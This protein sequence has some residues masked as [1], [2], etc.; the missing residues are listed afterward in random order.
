MDCSVCTSYEYIWLQPEERK[1]GERELRA[2][3]PP[4][5]ISPATGALRG[6]SC[7][8][9]RTGCGAWKGEAPPRRSSYKTMVLL[10]S[11]LQKEKKRRPALPRL[12]DQTPSS[13]RHDPQFCSHGNQTL[14]PGHTFCRDAKLKHIPSRDNTWWW[15]L[16]GAA[17]FVYSVS[18]SFL[19]YIY[20]CFLLVAL[21]DLRLLYLNQHAGFGAAHCFLR[22][23]RLRL[24]VVSTALRV[25][26]GGSHREVRLQRPAEYPDWDPRIHQESVHNWESDQ[27]NRS[28]VF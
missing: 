2:L 24:R 12:K 13:D 7:G 1:K 3:S 17:G 19:F 18:V 8:S 25:L 28:G 27:S 22:A 23:A 11:L 4:P 14:P 5:S 20:F 15:C 26:R 10:T 9:I 6:R 16:E 21:S